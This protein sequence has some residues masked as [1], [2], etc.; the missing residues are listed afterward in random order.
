MVD[1]ELSMGKYKGIILIPLMIIPLPSCLFL[2]PQKFS[3]TTAEKM[4]EREAGKE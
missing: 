1:K 2:A 4:K 3:L